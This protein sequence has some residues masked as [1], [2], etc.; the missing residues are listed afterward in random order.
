MGLNADLKL[1]G[2]DFNNAASAMY[3][4]N[5]IAELPTGTFYIFWTIRSIVTYVRPQGYIVQKVRPGKWL[6]LNVILWGVGTACTAA[7]T[8]YHGLVATRVMI[9]ILE[10]AT[11]PCLMLITGASLFGLPWIVH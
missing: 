10:A 9:G 7:M 6:G 3:I 2:N 1:K 11:A 8:N 4:A 5:L